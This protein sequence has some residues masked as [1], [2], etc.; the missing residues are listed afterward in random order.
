MGIYKQHEKNEK[1][2]KH[3]LSHTRSFNF[4]SPLETQQYIGIFI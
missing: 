1:K 2:Q 3:F 4:F